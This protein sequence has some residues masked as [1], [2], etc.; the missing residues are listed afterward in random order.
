MTHCKR[1]RFE[2]NR[3]IKLYLVAQITKVFN[4]LVEKARTLEETLGKNSKSSSSGVVNRSTEAASNSSR[5]GKRGHFYK[6][7]Q[8]VASSRGQDRQAT[9]VE[10][11]STD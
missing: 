1:F 4:E 5:K 2:L 9:I 10:V 3:E 8:R 6:S 7:G 11:G